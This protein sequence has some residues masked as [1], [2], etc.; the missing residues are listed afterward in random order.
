MSEPRWITLTQAIR[1]HGEQLAI[2]GGPAGLRDQG[3]LESALD[4]PRNKFQYGEHDL[5]V[6]A[7]SYA[8]GLA[9]NHP[10]IDGNKRAAFLVMV[11]FLRKNGIAF[12]PE[13]GEATQVMFDL[14]AGAMD[15][16]A[17]AAWVAVHCKA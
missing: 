6:L 9:K 1:M 7:A 15:E 13:Q 12:A 10:F 16:A 11:V 8:F 17:L 2:F 4:R 5:A 3:L 14:A